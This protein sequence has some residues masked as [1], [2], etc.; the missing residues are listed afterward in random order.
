MLGSAGA[1]IDRTVTAAKGSGLSS[2]LV[3]GAAA[4]GLAALLLS[5]KKARKFGTKALQ[6]GGMAAIGG[7]AYKAWSDYKDGQATR[8]AQ[9]PETPPGRP[10]P[11]GGSI[12]DLAGQQS[13]PED[14]NIRLSL[15]QAMISAAKADGHIDAAERARIEDKILQLGIGHDEQMFLVDALNAPSDPIAI[16]RLSVGEE[17]AAEL[18]VASALALDVD[19]STESRYLERLADALH[20][21]DALRARLDAETVR[22]VSA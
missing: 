2:G 4:G 20:L 6:Y 17:H 12:F 22:A 15:V 1:G 16:A 18:Y 19:T 9:P 5:N 7:L 11:P 14:E 21:P 13:A 8:T 10:R 3:G